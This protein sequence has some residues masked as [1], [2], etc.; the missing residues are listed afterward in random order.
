MTYIPV[1]VDT[2]PVDLA[3]EAFVYLEDKVPGWLPSPGNL[4][5][6][7]IE[8][9]AEIAGELRVLTGLVP[10]SIFEYFG[11]S[12]MGLPPYEA[13]EATGDT[14]WTATDTAGYAV[15]AGTLIAVRPPATND[16]F[17]FEVIDSFSIPAGSTVT[18]PVAVRA[19]QPGANASGITGTVEMLDPLDFIAGVT[20]DAPT[21]GGIDAETGD[22]YLSRLSDLMTLL[23]P[24]PILPKDFAVLAQRMIPGVARSVAIDLYNASTQQTDQPRCV[25]V[26]AID[27]DGEAVSSAIK[28]EI[29]DLLQSMREVNFLVWEADPTYTTI[30]VTYDVVCYPEQV[31]ADVIARTTANL[32]KYLSPANW[33]LPPYG[34]TSARSWINQTVVRYLEIS[35]VINRT[36]GVHYINTLTICV[37]G[38][39]MG[40]ADIALTGVA[41]LTRPGTMTGTGSVE[42]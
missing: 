23:T 35:E 30:D 32:N 11:S 41:P 39:T 38:G 18:T 34:D 31:A 33:G 4:E 14:T 15:N 17:A 8:A 21:T 16:A 25:T 40:T 37:S 10:N 13:T 19:L 42:T 36:D 12:I 1:Q 20:L 2:E 6:W 24:R 3:S 5:A 27:E 26:V 9:L 7:L 29:D 22:D 28:Q